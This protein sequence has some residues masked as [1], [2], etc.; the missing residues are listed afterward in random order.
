[1]ALILKITLYKLFVTKWKCSPQILVIIYHKTFWLYIC[2][3]ENKNL[4]TPIQS[5]VNWKRDFP[6][7]ILSILFLTSTNFC[8]TS[9]IA[10]M[11]MSVYDMVLFR[12]LSDRG[13]FRI[14]TDR[15]LLKVL[16]DKLLFRIFSVIMSFFIQCYQ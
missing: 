6:Q 9:T 14:L 12:V 4:W 2:L 15:V 10:H 7:P 8:I 11:V 1:M 16:N 5:A 3:L 13:L